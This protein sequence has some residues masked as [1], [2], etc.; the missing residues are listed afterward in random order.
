MKKDTKDMKFEVA[1][2]KLESIVKNLETGES[3]LDDSIKMFEDGVKLS[4]FCREKLDAAQ[5]K[6]EILK[7]TEEGNIETE[8]FDTSINYFYGGL[9]YGGGNEKWE[10]YVA[11]AVGATRFS[12]DAPDSSSITKFSFSVGAG[13]K[14]YLSERIRSGLLLSPNETSGVKEV[15]EQRRH[16]ESLG[17]LQRVLNA[18]LR[19]FDVI[20]RE[21]QD[22]ETVFR[23]DA[24]ERSIG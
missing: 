8:L 9:L 2:D 5:R 4:R 21:R 20:R 16:R 7:K 12:P 19:L 17:D 13:L 14:A 6:I 3:S 1:L 22:G 18:T 24:I 11:F 15:G 10:P 23:G